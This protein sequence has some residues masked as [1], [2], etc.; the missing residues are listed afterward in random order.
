MK[1]ATF[2]QKN[3]LPRSYFEPKKKKKKTI[4]RFMKNK[5]TWQPFFFFFFQIQ[6]LKTVQIL[7]NF[8]FKNS[9]KIC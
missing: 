5:T 9:C 8:M 1:K 6:S 7:D 2:Y 4:P 3:Y